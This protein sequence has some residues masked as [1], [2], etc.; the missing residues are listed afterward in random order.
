MRHVP[1]DK[2]NVAWFK[3]AECVSRREKERALGV[4]RLLAHSFGDEAF[5]HQ[6]MGDLLSAFDD[7]QAIESYKKAA[8]L[9]QDDARWLEAAAVYEHLAY[10]E[11]QSISHRQSVVEMYKKTSLDGKIITSLS[12]LFEQMIAIQDLDGARLALKQLEAYLP[13]EELASLHQQLVYELLKR[14]SIIPDIVLEHIHR[15]I[16]GLFTRNQAKELTQFLNYLEQAGNFYYTE[17]SKY[18]ES[19]VFKG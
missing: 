7:Q 9:Y 13:V 14:P 12:V 8:Q 6:L 11:P 18:I 4:Y 10:I 15:T 3:L 5:A 17:A 19:D 16:D 2:Y 1:S